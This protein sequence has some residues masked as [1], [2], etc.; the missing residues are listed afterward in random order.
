MR[1]LFLHI[2]AHKTGTTTL[3]RAL[4]QNQSALAGRGFG[5]ASSAL[6]PNLHPFVGPGQGNSFLP[7]GF[8]VTDPQGLV[9]A[10]AAPEQ[11]QVI[12]SSENFSFF[13]DAAAVSALADLVRPHFDEVRIVTYL[14]RQD[15]H[16]VSHHQEGAKPNRSPE[17]ALW[18]HAPRALPDM[19]EVQDLYL[20]YDRRLTPWADAFGEANMLIRVYD[21]SMLRNG[22]IV[23]DF[24]AA[25]GLGDLPLQT[26]GDRNVSL[27]AAQAKIGHLMASGGVAA[28]VAST[29]LKAMPRTGKLLP[30]KDQARAFLAR[31]DQSNRRLNQR[32]GV[33]GQPDLFDADFADYPDEA[34]N[35]W[36]EDTATEAIRAVLPHL[37]GSVPPVSLADLRS[38]AEALQKNKPDVAL[39]FVRAALAQ[40]P[41]GPALLKLEAR[42]LQRLASPAA[43]ATADQTDA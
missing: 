39:R 23:A 11:P 3:Q 4:S 43:D 14:R 10:L 13:F 12:A 42:L 2:G 33:A 1:R 36:T 6:F 29:V 5:Y 16:A 9:A 17:G 34:E 28:E 41:T 35:D 32:F 38:A 22:D 27:G 21:R 19:A 24:L 26:S 18:G 40:R 8:R 37:E 30:S 7:S 25:L 31:Y 20:D 15:R